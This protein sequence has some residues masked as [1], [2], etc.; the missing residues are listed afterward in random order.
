MHGWLAEDLPCIAMLVDHAQRSFTQAL[1]ANG[2]DWLFIGIEHGPIDI[3]SAHAL[4]AATAG[5]QSAPIVRVP[6]TS[7]G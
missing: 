3:A 6:G 2:F 1:T 4:I 7:P 5:T